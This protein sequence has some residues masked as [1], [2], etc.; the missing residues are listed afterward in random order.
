MLNSLRRL[1]KLNEG[2]AKR[3]D[4]TPIAEEKDLQV[5][6]YNEN[7]PPTDQE[8]FDA[9]IQAREEAESA[10][11]NIDSVPD[12]DVEVIDT[13]Y[14]E[15]S[16]EVVGY[17]SREQQWN[18][19]HA[20]SK[21]ILENDSVLDFGC[22]RG[23]LKLFFKN[24]LGRAIDYH[25]VDNNKI[26]IDSGLKIYPNIN[27]E[28]KDWFDIKKNKKAN[29]CVNI[30]SVNLRYDADTTITDTEYL[31]KT[32]TKMYEQATSG[33]IVMLASTVA[34]IDDGLINRDPGE[35]L[36]WT[37]KTFPKSGVLL[38]HTF[39]DALFNLIIYKK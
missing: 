2:R 7:N 31:Q 4:V 19:Y 30:S 25:G 20:I 26:M 32:I 13:D 8:V 5:E 36:A 39:S 33:V 37:L 35:V 11:D 38:D 28:H 17:E 14:L 6:A 34:G 23:D 22:G 1:L 9:N 27:I 15:H 24:E 16:S 29:W 12:P 3:K 18:T 10:A 21:F